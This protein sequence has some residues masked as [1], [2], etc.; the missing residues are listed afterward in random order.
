M[1]AATGTWVLFSV[2][3]QPAHSAVHEPGRQRVPLALSH[4][5]VARQLLHDRLVHRVAARGA[6]RRLQVSLRV[7]RLRHRPLEGRSRPCS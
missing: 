7:R 2:Q 6:A 4:V 5:S 3:Q 1:P